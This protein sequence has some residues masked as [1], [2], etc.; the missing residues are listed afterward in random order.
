VRAMVTASMQLRTLCVTDTCFWQQEAT[1]GSW[2]YPP[3][4]GID[5][6]VEAIIATVRVFRRVTRLMKQR[7]NLE[8]THC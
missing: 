4:F 8:S 5:S 2:L 7:I 6:L 1:V 3:Q